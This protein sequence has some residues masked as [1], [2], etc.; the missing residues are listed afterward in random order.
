MSSKRLKLYDDFLELVIDKKTKRIL[1]RIAYKNKMT[2][3][4]YVRNLIAIDILKHHHDE[5]TDDLVRTTE[6]IVLR[7]LR[8]LFND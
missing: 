5:L 8:G 1:R 6:L 2:M 4:E 3:S 7:T